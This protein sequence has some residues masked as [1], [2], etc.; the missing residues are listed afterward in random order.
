[1]DPKQ[2]K[3]SV[4][5]NNEELARLLSGAS[6]MKTY[7]LKEK[8]C[9]SLLLS[10]GPIGVRMEDANGDSLAGI[11][12]TL[13]STCFPA[14]S[15]L[16]S[17]FD[18]SLLKEIGEA[19][20][21]EAHH[22]EADV[23]LGPAM[24]IM[25][26]PLGGRNFEYYSED[27]FLTGSLA[28]SYVVGMQSTGTGSCLKHFAGNNNET[29][30][31]VGDSSIDS[32]ALHDIYL[33]GYE[34]AVKNSHP[35]AVMT[36]YNR[37]NGVFC[38][39]NGYLLNQV[40]RQDWGFD[41]LVMTDWGGIV[42]RV[43]ALKNGCDLEMPGMS[44]HN[45]N[46]TKKSL[47]DGSL[48]LS[49]AEASGERISLL[50]ERTK[51]GKGGPDFFGE[52]FELAKKAALESVVLLKNDGILPLSEGEDIC[53]IGSLFETPRYQG[54]GSSMLNPAIFVS[55]RSAMAERNLR[56]EY[57]EGYDQF[58]NEPNSKKEKAALDL[59]KKHDIIL[60]Y[61]G[62]TDFMESEGFDRSDMKLPKN[63]LSL[64]NKLFGLNKKI[65]FVYF[66][67]NSV[68][69]PFINNING[70]LDMGLP[71]EA[72]GEV[73]MDVLFGYSSPS[74]RLTYTWPLSY[75]D[76]PFGK[77]FAKS[78]NELYKESIYVGY[79]YYASANK[80][81]LFPF[82]FGLSYSKFKCSDMRVKK[83]EDGL[84]VSLNVSNVGASVS[85]Y[86]VQAY[87]GSSIRG[88]PMPR[89]ELK[90]FVRVKLN[91]GE[92][93]GVVIKIPFES[94]KV[95]DAVSKSEILAKGLYK[96]EIC[97]D[98][99]SPLMDEKIELGEADIV[100][101]YGGD[102]LRKMESPQTLTTITDDDFALMLG[103]DVS[104][105]E[106]DSR[107]Y[108]METAIRDFKT[109]FG[110][111]FKWVTAYV[112]LRQYRK[113]KRLKDAAKRERECKAGYF[114]Y[115]LM[116]NNSLRSLC[117]SSSG[118]FKYNI[119][120]GI[121]LMANHHLIKGLIAMCKKEK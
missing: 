68:E 77:E 44:F 11:S 5:L 40:L 84:L 31:F 33:K 103:R 60:F 116:G 8:G 112:G 48:P 69:M 120:Q 10:D 26:N 83:E 21:L 41:G 50:G 99:L 52:H 82:G 72:V 12:R 79:R 43:K 51:D 3:T 25:R 42:D 7:E 78:K 24:N 9:R 121:L 104:K 1:M 93:E 118:S 63:Q 4:S 114:V 109:P 6:T 89:R 106:H 56:Y 54:S 108:D 15:T 113:G 81:V 23:V 13:P 35:W 88:F 47:D 22:Y 39:Q 70:L 58:E 14:G 98:S 29:N 105:D 90:G 65:V 46:L 110:R 19:I 117:Y 55:H 87:V 45:I 62:L 34:M 74:G 86:I 115:R 27:P 20:G 85:S 57:E 37:V 28:S 96:I 119:A 67:G 75:E 95:Y 76:V 92:K 107:P 101:P 17:S 97:E 36:A 73:T 71:G 59:A 49:M 61:G 91:P 32:R 111:F 53:I 102:A 100:S 94:L 66:G 80:N 30:R 18:V 16:A 64:L 38:S 2:N